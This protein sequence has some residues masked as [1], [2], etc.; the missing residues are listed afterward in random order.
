MNELRFIEISDEHHKGVTRH[1]PWRVTVCYFVVGILWIF[2]SDKL[3]DMLVA[4][5]ELYDFIQTIK[6][7]AY[8]VL[9]AIGLHYLMK[10]DQKKILKTNKRLVENQEELLAYSEELITSEDQLQ[11]NV[12]EMAELSETLREQIN[13]NEAVFNST[14]NAILIWDA[15][16]RIIKINSVCTEMFGY[17]QEV[18]GKNL[19]DVFADGN[20]DFDEKFQAEM[21]RFDTINN[22]E[23]EVLARNQRKLK[24]TWNISK[25][26]D[27]IDSETLYIGFGIDVTRIYEKEDELTRMKD[28]DY[29]TQLA[30]KQVFYSDNKKWLDN[31]RH[32]RYYLV[33]IDNFSTLND[34]YGQEHGDRY[35]KEVSEDITAIESVKAYRWNGDEI[36]IVEDSMM[37]RNYDE[38]I[39][40]IKNIFA[41][42]RN[43]DS[44][45]YRTKVSIG[46]LEQTGDFFTSKQ[47]TQ[48]LHVALKKA[49]ELGRNR[50]VEFEESYLEE[51]IYKNNLKELIQS[52]L[53]DNGFEVYLQPIYHMLEKRIQYYE[54]LLRCGKDNIQVDIGEL[55]AYAEKTG[56]I[57]E[58]DRWVIENACKYLSIYNSEENVEL[59]HVSVNISPQSFYLTGFEQYLEHCINKYNI[60]PSRISLEITE[61]SLLKNI[62]ESEIIF[63]RLKEMGFKM[64]LDDFGTE[65]SSLN[66][67]SK[68]PFDTLKI[69]KSYVDNLC[70][71]MKDK[72][73]I[74]NLILLAKDLEIDI[75]AEGIE[76]QN[77]REQL[78]D[79]GCQYGQGYLLSKPKWIED[80]LKAK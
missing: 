63:S 9:T 45:C 12:K 17:G 11:K 14:N 2:F 73:I 47:I 32:M 23:I 66:Y 8:I 33:G 46:V 6:G 30:H 20:I 36:L 62:K 26:N 78:I 61:Y 59:E 39:F 42:E 28:V 44:V 54:V 51:I 40:E 5:H 25:L 43:F 71:N 57:I 24:V 4:S 38:R 7:S 76:S 19:M 50:H 58:I 77:Q 48:R 72:L 41:K 34:L 49:K 70:D 74:K 80:I 31:K 64:S 13:L 60:S 52:M 37:N 10:L 22:Y 18:V 3:L 67:L 79:F 75:V 68:L 55:I 21:K 15:S 53:D 16:Y 35:L 65:Y 56:Q 69:D 27:V 29:L 1:T